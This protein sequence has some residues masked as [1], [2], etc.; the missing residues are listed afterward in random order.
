M[1]G[2]YSPNEVVG[3]H[4]PSASMSSVANTNSKLVID[5]RERQAT[6]FLDLDRQADRIIQHDWYIRSFVCPRQVHKTGILVEK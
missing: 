3:G 1:A 6:S 5:D 2:A 4:V